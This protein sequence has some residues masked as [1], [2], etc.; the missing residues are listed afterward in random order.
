MMLILFGL[1][2]LFVAGSAAVAEP[3]TD[4]RWSDGRY[5]I[6]IDGTR[7]SPTEWRSLLENSQRLAGPQ[8]LV[9]GIQWPGGGCEGVDL[10]RYQ[11]QR[12][13]WAY[14][15]SSFPIAVTVNADVVQYYRTSV[16]QLATREQTHSTLKYASLE[17]TPRV[18][19]ALKYQLGSTLYKDVFLV[20]LPLRLKFG[21]DG[22]H[23]ELRMERVLVY[24]KRKKLLTTSGDGMVMPNTVCY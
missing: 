16:K 18:T 14:C 5:E 8:D 2:S 21:G 15:D 20:R 9:D 23:S 13:W 11:D 17:Y 24:S 12:R 6:T 4:E 3:I 22:C 7:P 19:H 1:V 10:A